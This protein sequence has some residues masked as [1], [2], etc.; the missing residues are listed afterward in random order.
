MAARIST[1][2][3]ATSAITWAPGSIAGVYRPVG[4]RANKLLR[5]SRPRVVPPVHLAQPAGCDVRIDLRRADVGVS[6]E[7]LHDAEVGAAGEEVRRE[8]VPERVRRDAEIGRASCRE[9]GYS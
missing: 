1:A 2:T 3:T 5:A 7:R 8:R 4:G 9:R 6:E